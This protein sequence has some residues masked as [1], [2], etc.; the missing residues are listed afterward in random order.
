MTPSIYVKE[1]LIKNSFIQSKIKNVANG[2]DVLHFNPKR[3]PDERRGCVKVGYV[4]Y[5]GRHKGIEHL[6]KA[7]SLIPRESKIKLDITSFGNEQEYFSFL[8]GYIMKLGIKERV[9]FLRQVPNQRIAGVYKNMDIFVLPS[10]WPENQPVS[11]CEAM[12]SGVSV[13][14]SD[15]GGVR[16]LIEHDHTGLLFPLGDAL[17][18]SQHIQFLA[19]NK[20]QRER[21]AENGF[22]KI[23]QLD[24]TPQARKIE[25]IYFQ[26]IKD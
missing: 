25:E 14:A 20:S 21:L 2:I 15:V 18:L 10:I 9:N 16:E 4:G 26:T 22:N 5:L 12:A 19:T 7:I 24:L 6:L 8:T 13:I 11:I 1:L 3:I 23:K 17:K